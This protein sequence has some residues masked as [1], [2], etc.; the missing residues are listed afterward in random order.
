M[1]DDATLV[2]AL[3][4]YGADVNLAADARWPSFSGESRDESLFHEQPE[5]VYPI[6]C[7]VL[8]S[9]HSRVKA[10]LEAGA[11][12]NARTSVWQ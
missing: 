3:I 9:M 8:S 6:H 5:L 11:D 10:L 7:A 4:E 2:C 12:I 1:K